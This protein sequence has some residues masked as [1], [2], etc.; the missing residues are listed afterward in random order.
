MGT[1]TSCKEKFRKENFQ[2]GFVVNRERGWFL[3]YW[4]QQL[5]KFEE[6]K[7]FGLS[8]QFCLYEKREVNT[9]EKIS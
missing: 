3:S 6:K 9:F 1:E 7:R 5:I 8:K 2:I 4:N